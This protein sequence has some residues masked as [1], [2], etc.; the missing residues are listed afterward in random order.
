MLGSPQFRS[1]VST[2][3]DKLHE[4]RVC[5]VVDIDLEGG[6]MYPVLVEFIVPAE[7]NDLTI[8]AECRDTGRDAHRASA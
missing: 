8:G 1:A 7:G 3:R 4:L 6:N 2:R 5:N